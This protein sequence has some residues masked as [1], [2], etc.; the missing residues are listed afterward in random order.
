MPHKDPEAARD[1]QRLYWQTHSPHRSTESLEKRRAY[2]RAWHKLHLDEQ[3]AYM[4]VWREAHRQQYRVYSLVRR[5]RQS[6]VSF[7]P[8]DFEAIKMRDRMHCCICG[9]KVANKDLSFDHT[10]PLSLGGSHSQ[11]NLRVSHRCCNQRRN[12]AWL[13]VQ[14]VMI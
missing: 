3:R 7:N 9:K 2:V 10:V 14:M 1:Y 13:P 8:V 6:G 11:E 5:A 4:Q 12:V